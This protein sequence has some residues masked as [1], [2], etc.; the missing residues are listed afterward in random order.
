LNYQES[1]DVI[2]LDKRKDRTLIS[3]CTGRINKAKETESC[4]KGISE[5]EVW[6]EA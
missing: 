2:V 4:E 3:F 1:A 5:R 6:M